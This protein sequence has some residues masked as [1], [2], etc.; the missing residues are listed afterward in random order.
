M[1]D[2]TAS[3]GGGVGGGAD[4]VTEGTRLGIERLGRFGIYP[5]AD[6]S[7]LSDDVRSR[8]APRMS[9]A[10]A[11]AVEMMAE[12]VA[13]ALLVRREYGE[14]ELTAGQVNSYL[15]VAQPFFNSLWHDTP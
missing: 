11:R 14:P 2:L 5:T 9:R 12:Q 7:E 10:P 13:V 1:T 6:L 15:D 4:P 3:R 8:L